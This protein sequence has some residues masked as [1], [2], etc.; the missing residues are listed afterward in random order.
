RASGQEDIVVGSPSANR[1]RAELEGL[2]GFFINRLLLRTTCSDRMSFRDFLEQVREVALEA[3]AHQDLPF[4]QLVKALRPER[5]ASYNPLF[6]V[7]FSYQNIP[8]ANLEFSDLTLTFA[9]IDH[10]TT[11]F[12]M[13]L[14]IV[15][16]GQELLGEWEYSTD[17]FDE[18][19]IAR[20]AGQLQCLLES[21]VS[22]PTR[23]IGQLQW[24]T[25]AESHQLLV[26][27]NDTHRDLC[28]RPCIHQ[29]FEAQVKQAPQAMAVVFEEEKLSYQELNKRANRL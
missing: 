29:M 11:K 22:N 5:N 7:E 18:T 23:A 26:E 9:D 12:D 14:E 8:G 3:Y 17:L 6:Q 20:M 16:T 25:Q 21:I 4:D 10:R 2:I 13:A 19:T 28:Q 24:V 1:T 27:W 15:D